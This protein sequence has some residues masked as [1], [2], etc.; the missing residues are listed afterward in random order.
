MQHHHQNPPQQP[1]WPKEFEVQS[2]FTKISLVNSMLVNISTAQVALGY[3]F[4]EQA[5][6]YIKKSLGYL[7]ELAMQGEVSIKS[8]E[9]VYSL[10][11]GEAS[12]WLAISK[13][14]RVDSVVNEFFKKSE[15]A[16]INLL[17]SEAKETNTYVKPLL[18]KYCL[19]KAVKSISEKQ[20]ETC[21]HFLDE[22]QYCVFVEAK[23][24]ELPIEKLRDKLI[25]ARNFIKFENVRIALS[26]LSQARIYF[27][28]NE[29]AF[30]KNL[31]NA[32]KLQQIFANFE[33]IQIVLKT[34]NNND[35][36]ISVKRL[37]NLIEK[38][39]TLE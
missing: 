37:N 22:I 15:T 33:M 11:H 36:E 39:D 3:G 28:L 26:A 32:E 7:A 12:A 27:E 19:E 21:I 9:V 14:G 30:S 1:I 13:G 16:R 31:K 18:L 29:T 35:L 5:A 10:M 4:H 2:D 6:V 20:Y 23:D 25:L 38:L 8:G 24:L 34:N 17:R